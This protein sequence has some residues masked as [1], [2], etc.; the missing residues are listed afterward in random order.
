MKTTDGPAPGAPRGNKPAGPAPLI[1]AGTF[2]VDYHKVLDHYPAERTGARV[3]REMVSHGGAP[4]NVLVCLAKLGAGFPLHAAAKVGR[5]LDGRF[6]LDCCRSHGIDTTQITAVEDAATGYTD[7][8]TVAA[9]GRHTCFHYSGIGDTFA[10]NDVKLRAV[11]PGMLFLGSLGALGKMDNPSPRLGRTG[12]AQLIREARKQGITTVI[13]ISPIDLD[14]GLDSFRETLAQADYLV[15]SDGVAERLTGIE[16]H[17]DGRFDPELARRAAGLFLRAGLR[18]AVVIHAR[19]GA[20]MLAAGGEHHHQPGWFLP[21]PLRK[22]SA[23]A[24]HA[25][26]AGFIEGL[27]HGRPAAECLEQGLAAAIM[28]RREIPPSDGVGTMAQCLEFC[29]RLETRG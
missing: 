15:I 16:L 13:E 23:G 11:S 22:G 12:A 10:R 8:Y 19:G 20:C 29:R 24:D 6:I 7:V 2:V 25:F 4:F 1:A 21:A 18:K 28:C 17:D 26:T 27:H 5:D 9:N 3:R 14:R